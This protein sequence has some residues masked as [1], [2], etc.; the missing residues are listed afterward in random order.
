M[1]DRYCPTLGGRVLLREFRTTAAAFGILVLIGFLGTLAFPELAQKILAHFLSRLD[2]LGLAED[3]E[4]AQ[5]VSTLFYNNLHASF[6]SI[7]YGLIPFLYLSV[8]SIGTN[9]LL[10]GVFAALYQQ[11]GIGLAAYLV[12]TLPHG[13]FEL[14]ALILSCAMGLLL[15]TTVT[16]R[17]RKKSSVSL[18]QLLGDCSRVFLCAVVPLLLIAALVESYITPLLLAAVM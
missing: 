13:I 9:A 8:L 15:C 12:G 3:T 18:L 7:L 6:L 2:Q 11:Q 1:I 10:L 4:A 14:T 17:L 5:M 16:D